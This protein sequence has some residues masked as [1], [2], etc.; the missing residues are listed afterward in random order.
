MKEEKN[1][2]E[3]Q[4]KKFDFKEL[5]T[6]EKKRARLIL[7][8]YFIFFVVL[9]IGIRGANYKEDKT[10]HTINHQADE[11]LMMNNYEFTYTITKGEK[12]YI[13]TGKHYNEKELF[14]YNKVE[15]YKENNVFL[16]K[17]NKE[18][19]KT[20]NPYQEY[21]L[22]QLDQLDKILEKSDFLS[23]TKYNDS[24]ILNSYKMYLDGK[25][26]DNVLNITSKKDKLIKIEM[27]FE[28][29]QIV[30]EYTNVGNVV[31]FDI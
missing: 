20:E 21:N 28:N 19:V 4:K 11:K 5:F 24:S 26:T 23:Q 15:Y 27:L 12:K 31:N 16:K 29:K 8:V 9:I 6:D 18:W 22:L 2:K 25:V 17:E 7:L 1:K 14:T 10:A 30:L 3:V 13:Y